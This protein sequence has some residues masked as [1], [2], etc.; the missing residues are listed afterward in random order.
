MLVQFNENPVSWIYFFSFIILIAMI[1]MNMIVG[2]IIDV[3]VQEN[4]AEVQAE[5]E[6]LE[7]LGKIEKR[8]DKLG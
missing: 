7:K 3:I 2:V 6:I 5:K 8:L 4:K 1:L